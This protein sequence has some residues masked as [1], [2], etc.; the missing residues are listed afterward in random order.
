MFFQ[1]DYNAPPEEESPPAGGARLF[2]WLLGGEA[3]GLLK[4]N[5]LFLLA[6]LPVVTI[7][8]AYHALHRLARR[9]VQGRGVR[10]WPQFW[11]TVR[12]EWKTAWAAF[13][14]TALPLAGAGYGMQ[15]YLQFAGRNPVF[16]LPFTL[17]ATIFLSALLASSYLW[18]LLADGR[19]LDRETVLLAV[20]LGLGKPLR[21]V[22]A[23][24]GW[25]LSLTAAA[26][27]FPLSGIYLLLM[28]F[29]VPCLL[30]Q[31]LIR[32]VLERF[33]SAENMDR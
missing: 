10:C 4:L 32:T 16:Y 30:W 17:C 3:A 9:L 28:G 31:F 21:A 29:S 7:P 11:E 2:F 26:L 6:C 15:F 23:A 27:W 19:R 20:K 14:L 5:L 8:P 22:L 18:G 24:A 12:R 13:L 1:E 33:G 25:Y